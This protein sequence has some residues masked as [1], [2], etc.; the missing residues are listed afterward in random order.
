M[1]DEATRLD[2]EIFACVCNEF[3]KHTPAVDVQEVQHRRAKKRKQREMPPDAQ[4]D[5][6]PEDDG[7]GPPRALC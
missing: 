4:P 1:A 6:S 2:R 3:S 7:C 5:A